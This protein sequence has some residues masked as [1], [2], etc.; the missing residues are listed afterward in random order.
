MIT[1][2]VLER[3]FNAGEKLPRARIEKREAQYLYSMG[4]DFV[5]MDTE[6]FEQMTVTRKDIGSGALYLKE[7]M[8]VMVL[9]YDNRVIGVEV[10]NFVELKVV[11]TEPGFKGD[12]ATGGSKLAKLETGAEVKVPLFV[13]TDD[14]IKVDTR[15]NEY[16]ERVQ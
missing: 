6:T 7:N 14:V 9:S 5:L 15:T 3:T 11:E 1:G 10:P 13:S 16:I 8:N 4:E 12:T 2:A